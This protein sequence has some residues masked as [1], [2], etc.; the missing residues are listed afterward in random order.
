MTWKCDCGYVWEDHSHACPK[1]GDYG[2]Y[3]LQCELDDE[4]LRDASNSSDLKYRI[5]RI[6][7][8]KESKS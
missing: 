1:C 5:W 7:Q 4:Y 6:N 3:Q 2:A 8:R